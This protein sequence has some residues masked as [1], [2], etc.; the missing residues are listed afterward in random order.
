[1]NLFIY[2]TAKV[3]THD[4]FSAND[5]GSWYPQKVLKPQGVR[6]TLY[7]GT[8]YRTQHACPLGLLS[9]GAFVRRGFY[10]LGL[11]SVGAFIRGAF[12]GRAFFGGAFVRGAFVRGAFV[13][14]PLLTAKL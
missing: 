6:E 14:T 7:P 4:F 11:L 12:F 8:F 1:M 13:R 2:L 9:A 10:P 5:R 3:Y